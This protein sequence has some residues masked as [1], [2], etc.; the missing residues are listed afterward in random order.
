MTSWHSYPKVYNLGHRCIADLFNDPVIVQEKVDGSQFSF[1]LFGDAIKVRSRGQEMNP[2]APESLFE[3]AV[4]TVMGLAGELHEGW[5][6]R[7]EYLAKPKHNSLAYSRIPA[8]HV[9]LFDINDGEE[10]YLPYEFAG[11]EAARLGLEVVPCVHVGKIESVDAIMALMDRESIL[12]GQKI[13][14][15]VIKNYD[16]FGL[17]KK[18]LMGKHVSEAFKEVHS[19]EWKTSNPQTGDILDLLKMEYRT[20]ARWQKAVQHLAEAGV[21]LNEPKDIGALIKTVRE[22]IATECEAEIKE[23]LWRWARPHVA[24]SAA[25]GLPEWYKNKL[26]ESQF[27]ESVE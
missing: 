24:R 12:G 25:A 21:L 18:V 16:R 17:D 3:S 22:D 13:E 9:I 19:K 5:T 1:G 7:G 10:S 20:E 4:K 23:K 14:G 6:Y 15:L 2:S 8:Q 26:A 11:K 27:A